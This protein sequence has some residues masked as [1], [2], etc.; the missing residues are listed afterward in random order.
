MTK[1][2]DVYTIL[3]GTA[4]LIGIGVA[5]GSVPMMI[6]GGGSLAYICYDY[7]KGMF[8][9]KY[10][11]LFHNCGLEN[12]DDDLPKLVKSY[13]TGIGK[14]LVFDVPVGLTVFQFEDKIDPI[15]QFFKAN[16]LIKRRDDYKMLVQVIEKDFEKSYPVSLLEEPCKSLRGMRFAIG[17]KQSESGEEVA[18]IDYDKCEGHILINGGTGGGKSTLLRLIIAQA[19]LKN[20]TIHAL[21]MKGTEITSFDGYDKLVYS[22]DVENGLIQLTKLYDLMTERNHFLTDNRCKDIAEYNKKFPNAKLEQVFIIIDEFAPFR[23][24][25][26]VK[27]MLST[28]LSMSRSAGMYFILSTQRIDSKTLGDIK[29]NMGISLNMKTLT[30]ADSRI[31]MNSDKA[32]Y[33]PGKGRIYMKYDDEL[34]R[35]VQV[36]FLDND[37]CKEQLGDKLS[38]ESYD[39]FRNNGKEYDLDLYT[40]NVIK[41]GSTPLNT[42]TNLQDIEKEVNQQREELRKVQQQAMEAVADSVVT[43]NPQDVSNLEEVDEMESRRTVTSMY[44]RK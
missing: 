20:I 37:P 29:V 11:K 33:L 40:G 5:S 22:R 27:K 18:V 30:V 23:A 15:E 44:V 2:A 35:M 28:L 38:G 6:L 3:M 26:E 4:A 21:D 41:N 42:P 24:D 12:K 8:S 19:I 9:P 17:V 13:K 34:D 43:D 32:F 31:A 7:A 25:S 10:D 36:Y 14:N 1:L 16:V 39:T